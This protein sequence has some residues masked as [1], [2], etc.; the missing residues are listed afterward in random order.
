MLGAEGRPSDDSSRE[1]SSLWE[2]SVIRTRSQKAWVT[3][4][5]LAASRR[6]AS[7]A[8]RVAPA[9]RSESSGAV[10]RRPTT[11]FQRLVL[12]NRPNLRWPIAP[13]SCKEIVA[14]AE[15]F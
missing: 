4:G 15:Q 13:R 11:S 5:L 1:K 14:R 3:D 7:A 8:E 6:A 10:S 2:A 9:I 12:G